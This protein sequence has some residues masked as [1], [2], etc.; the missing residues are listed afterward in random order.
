[1]TPTPMMLNVDTI[2]IY[3]GIRDSIGISRIGWIDVDSENPSILK[4]VSAEPVLD[5]GKDGMFDDNGIILGDILRLSA[6][7]LRMYYIG[8]QLVEKA[9]FLA[10]TGLAISI[11]GGSSFERYSN[12]PV[13]DRT[14]THPYISALHSIAKTKNGYRAWI[15]RGDGWQNIRETLYPKYDCWCVD[16][17]DGIRFELDNA[18]KIISPSSKEYRIGRP[19][20]SKLAEG[21]WILYATSDTFEKKYQT[22]FFTSTD[23]INFNRQVN[24]V[25]PLGV[26][27]SW[28]SEMICYPAYLKTPSGREYLFY[29]GN[30]MGRTGV[31]Y[32]IR[33]I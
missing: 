14:S 15:S 19:R 4:S 8:F 7:D 28:D 30:D 11:D 1:M 26:A 25:L 18:R 3:G 12:V 33:R 13:I 16:S 5:I 22:H 23:G 17:T 20:A 31:G 9:K 27:G 10:F 21:D 29:N 24:K 6:M 2:R 32:A